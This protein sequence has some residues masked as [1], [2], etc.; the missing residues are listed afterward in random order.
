MFGLSVGMK[1]DAVFLSDFPDFQQCGQFLAEIVDD[2]TVF[3][4]EI[5]IPQIYLEF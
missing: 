2:S 4:Y 3:Y 1:S 5:A